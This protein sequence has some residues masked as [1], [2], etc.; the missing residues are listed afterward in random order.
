MKYNNKT[1]RTSTHPINKINFDVKICCKYA[2]F[3]SF[4]ESSPEKAKQ[5]SVQ[6][7]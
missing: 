1:P 7:E 3:L 2:D 6:K 5:S 4:P